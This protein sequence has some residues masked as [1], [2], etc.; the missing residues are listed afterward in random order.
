MMNIRYL[1]F[2]GKNS[3][4]KYYTLEYLHYYLPPQPFRNER[5]RLLASIEERADRDYIHQR[6]DYYNKLAQKATL[7]K[8]AIKIKDLKL[9]AYHGSKV[10]LLDSHH[11]LKYFPANSRFILRDGDITYVPDAPAL[12]KSRPIAGDNSNSILLNM[13]KVRHFTFVNDPKGFGEK[14]DIILFRGAI[15]GKPH[16]KRFVEAYAD[17]PMCDCGDTSPRHQ[18]EEE[19][20]KPKMTIGE[21]LDYKYIMSLEGNDVASNLKWVMSSNSIAVMP[22]PKYETWFMEGTLKPDYHYIEIRPDYSDLVDK[23]QHYIDHPDEAEAIIANAHEHVRQFLD[24]KREKLISLLVLD[25]L[26]KL[27]QNE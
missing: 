8:E 19:Y 7:P 14:R 16:R 3:K 9:S 26:F 6:A 15:H 20:L 11:Y 2:S 4:L 5:E 21:H 18:A 10:Y 12:V 1:L 25:K 22:R 17:H 13:D 27:T 24:H 23:C